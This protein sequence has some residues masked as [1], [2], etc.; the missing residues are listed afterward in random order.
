[1]VDLILCSG[2]KLLT[3][4]NHFLHIFVNETKYVTNRYTDKISCAKDKLVS[5]E[6]E[7]Y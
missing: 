1:M 3:V 4:S 7:I 2:T 5:T 6:L